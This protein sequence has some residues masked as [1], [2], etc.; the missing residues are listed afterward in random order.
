[1]SFKFAI[2]KISRRSWGS[3]P[4]PA[5]PGSD[6]AG[7]LYFDVFYENGPMNILPGGGPGVGVQSFPVIAIQ[8]ILSRP[9]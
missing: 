6:R 5:A 7:G 8:L 1:M 3:A 4:P 9:D 2:M